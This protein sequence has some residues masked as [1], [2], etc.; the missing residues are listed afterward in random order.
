MRSTAQAAASLTFSS[1]SDSAR[2]RSCSGATVASRWPRAFATDRRTAGPRS[3]SVSR[4]A[5][6]ALSTALGCST[7]ICRSPWRH[8]RGRT[9]RHL[10]RL[11]LEEWTQIDRFWSRC[12]GISAHCGTFIGYQLLVGQLDCLRESLSRADGRFS[13]C[14]TLARTPPVRRGRR[15]S[16]GQFRGCVLAES[17]SVLP[18]RRSSGARLPSSSVAL[19][20]IG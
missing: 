9:P 6:M 1:G 11:Y 19:Y 18:A 15:A 8:S 14:L 12:S 5:G 17:H 13:D 7:A 16:V 20:C 2:D 10:V 4:R 3:S